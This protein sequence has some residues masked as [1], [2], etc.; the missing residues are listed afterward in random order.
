MKY[1]IYEHLKHGG[2]TYYNGKIINVNGKEIAQMSQTEPPKVYSSLNWAL[3]IVKTLK[4]RCKHQ[5]DFFIEDYGRCV[6]HKLRTG[7]WTG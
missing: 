7:E 3:R 5:G 2:K 6:N 4:K 1:V